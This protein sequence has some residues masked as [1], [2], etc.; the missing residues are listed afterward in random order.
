MKERFL[1]SKKLIANYYGFASV[2]LLLFYIWYRA[3]EGFEMNLLVFLV[4]YLLLFP[5]VLLFTRRY[6][7]QTFLFVLALITGVYSFYHYSVQ[8]HSFLNALYFTFQLFLLMTENVFTESGSAI[9]EYPATVEVA[10]WSAAGYTISTVFIAMYRMLEDSIRLSRYQLFGGHDVVI[11]YNEPAKRLLEDLSKH[12]KALVLI[13]ENVPFE[14]QEYLVENGIVVMNGKQ[15]DSDLYRR[16]GLEKAARIILIDEIDNKNLDELMTIDDYLSLRIKN[17][18]PHL[19]IHLTHLESQLLVE[20]YEREAI[21]QDRELPFLLQSVNMYQLLAHKLFDEHPL[22]RD[23]ETEVQAGLEQPFHLLVVGFKELGESIVLESLQRA[24]YYPKQRLKITI[25]AERV[26]RMKRQWQRQYPKSNYISEI[27]FQAFD[28]EADSLE[29]YIE[30]E[31]ASHVYLTDESLELMDGIDLTSLFPEKPIFMPFKKEGAI[32]RWI[33]STIDREHHLYSTG[34]VEEVLNEA[35][36]INEELTTQAEDLHDQFIGDKEEEIDKSS[37][38]KELPQYAK[39]NYYY[40]LSHAKIK[41]LLLGLQPFK[42][43]VMPYE[44]ISKEEFIEI[45]EPKLEELAAIEH[46]RWR[47]FY[48]MKGW[49]VLRGP[50]RN[51]IDVDNKLHRALVPYED[52]EDVSEQV[53]IHLQKRPK[54]A[55]LSLYDAFNSLGYDLV[56]FS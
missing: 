36:F 11:G 5:V 13:A 40:E 32:G 14:D 48:Y 43:G 8:D 24:H 26:G 29:E 1:K 44:A 45:V 35:Y 53:G 17:K 9:V 47:A 33:E 55:V 54:K 51:L 56:R 37:T 4:I 31:G 42:K 16:V 15:N 12:H 22:Y 49:D 21:G 10:R 7:F 41:L 38:Y 23:Y 52:L 50:G 19:V 20:R 46:H 34:L 28:F 25:L 27:H 6:A 30:K 3:S 39:E 18:K 2:L